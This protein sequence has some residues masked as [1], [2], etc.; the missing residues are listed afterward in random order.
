MSV[1]VVAQVARDLVVRVGRLPAEGSEPVV[2]RLERLG[3]KGASPADAGDLAARAATATVTRLGGRP[4]LTEL[5]RRPSAQ[6]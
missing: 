5:Q 1:V 2:E 6:T 3:G 4:D